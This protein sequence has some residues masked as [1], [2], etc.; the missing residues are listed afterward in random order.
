MKLKRKAR[1]NMEE[2]KLYSDCL[3]EFP[4]ELGFQPLQPFCIFNV[5]SDTMQEYGSVIFI[6]VIINSRD[7]TKD[8]VS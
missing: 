1:T 4:C 2:N 8:Q 3:T 6:T 5:V 7:R